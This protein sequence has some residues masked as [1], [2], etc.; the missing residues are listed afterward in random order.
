MGI[1]VIFSWIPI[2]VASREM[3]LGVK[4]NELGYIHG[5]GTQNEFLAPKS[6]SKQHFE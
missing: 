1:S 2:D 3:W 5:W 4:R 6:L